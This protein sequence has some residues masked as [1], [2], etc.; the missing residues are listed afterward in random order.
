MISVIVAV[1]NI[2][3]YIAKC[4]ESIINQTYKDLEI[5]LV[6]DGATDSSG[7]ICEEYAKKDS[8]I[9]VIHRVNGGL[10]AA[11][12]T[13]IEWAHGDFIAFV[14]GDD[15]IEPTMYEEM[16]NQALE[17][18][19]DFVACRYRCIYKD[20]V[21]DGS[22]DAVIV[23]EKPLSMLIKYLEEDEKVLIQHAA[24]N[25]LYHRDLLGEERFPEGKWYE[26][27][28]FSAKILSKVHKGVYVDHA[29][30]DYVCEREG[31]IMNAGL[32]ERI[33][34]DMIPAAL[35][36]ETFLDGFD[37]KEPVNIHRY[38]LYKRLL[39]FYR[40]LFKKENRKLKK[41]SKE[42]VHM[43]KGKKWTFSDVYAT[44]VAAKTEEIK[45]KMFIVSPLFFRMFMAVNDKFIL[46]IRLKRMEK[47]KC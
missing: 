40:E 21:I 11:R 10:S 13:G 33:F 6:D 9:K 36:K 43:V 42:I 22:T 15:W 32:T 46:P 29:L 30:Y 20:Y 35:E 27:V 38:Y 16:I 24:W 25:K 39:I 2:E 44:R 31:S 41:Y 7:Q 34:T 17:K 47:K 14:D 5:I 26:D 18:K 8:R 28:V 4:I 12:N 1:Y 3:K 19:A 37:N 45:T 23:F